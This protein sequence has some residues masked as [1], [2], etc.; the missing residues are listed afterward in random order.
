MPLNSFGKNLPGEGLLVFVSRMARRSAMRLGNDGLGELPFC[1]PTRRRPRISLP[2]QLFGAF[3]ARR[4]RGIFGLRL[5]RMEVCGHSHATSTRRNHHAPV[6]SCATNTPAS[7]RSFALGRVPAA[8]NAP[9]S[10]SGNRR[11]PQAAQH[12]RHRNK[13]HGILQRV[14]WK[15]LRQMPEV[16]RAR[17]D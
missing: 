2:P 4:M 13:Q 5:G 11:R 3:L 6:P 7:P 17:T 12:R 10:G 14:S 9:R 8:S 15:R 1:R 16:R